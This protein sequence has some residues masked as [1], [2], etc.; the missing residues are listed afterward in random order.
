MRRS[1]FL[2]LVLAVALSL[3]GAVRFGWALRGDLRDNA[4]I[5]ALHAGRDAEPRP[6]A[7][8]RAVAARALFLAWRGRTAE[9]ETLAPELA[10]GGAQLR[11]GVYL[12]IS[13]ARMRNAFELIEAGRLDDAIPEVALAKTGYRSALREWS[14]NYDAKVNLDLAMRLVR[15]MPRTGEAGGEEPEAQPRQLWTDLPG[16]PRGAP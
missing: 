13:N 3:A 4:T 6:G 12:A 16:L 7:D 5:R 14:E 2:L 1:P 10:R 9:A 8:P 15:D 11:S